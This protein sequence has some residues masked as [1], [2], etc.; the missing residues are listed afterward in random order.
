MGSAARARLFSVLA[1]LRVRLSRA[2]QRRAGGEVQT[3]P[4]PPSPGRGSELGAS[5]QRP[6][7]PAFLAAPAF[8]AGL[9]VGRLR[10][11]GRRGPEKRQPGRNP[12]IDP[13]G[14][15]ALPRLSS[16]EPPPAGSDRDWRLRLCL[17]EGEGVLWRRFPLTPPPSGSWACRVSAM[18]EGCARC[19]RLPP[20]RGPPRPP[21]LPYPGGLAAPRASPPQHPNR[22][23]PPASARRLRSP[24]PS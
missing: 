4:P 3:R 2:L 12:P 19:L 21:G 11:V 9:A 15:P 13:L 23:A 17:R 5:A 22:A 1:D 8:G 20:R 24:G 10:R 14:G 16:P 7:G 18:G 6:P